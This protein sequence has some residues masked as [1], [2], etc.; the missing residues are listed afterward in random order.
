MIADI[1]GI[2]KRVLFSNQIPLTNCKRQ[3]QLQTEQIF[4]QNILYTQDK[5]G[6][7]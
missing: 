4:L 5:S 6:K 2:L 3:R 1:C 7:I